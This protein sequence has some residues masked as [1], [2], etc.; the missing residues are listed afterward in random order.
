MAISRK[1]VAGKDSKK[2]KELGSLRRCPTELSPILLVRSLDWMSERIFLPPGS[3]GRCSKSDGSGLR[4]RLGFKN[5]AVFLRSSVGRSVAAHVAWVHHADSDKLAKAL[6]AH[7]EWA[8]AGEAARVE[9][10]VVVLR[11]IVPELRR[12]Y[13]AVADGLSVALTTQDAE[14]TSA[15][16]DRDMQDSLSHP[17]TVSFPSGEL[18][19]EATASV[20][21]P[22]PSPSETESAS[23]CRSF[24]LYSRL[25]RLVHG[26]EADVL[27]LLFDDGLCCDVPL[28]PLPDV[29]LLERLEAFCG[30]TFDPGMSL[31]AAA[32]TALHRDQWPASQ[33]LLLKAGFKFQ[34][35]CSRVGGRQVCCLCVGAEG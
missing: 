1:F 11:G 8:R 21:L 25:S 7:L 10:V 6:S 32:L 35:A 13:A 19:C 26:Q 4:V 3:A 24:H 5:A 20:S 27:P 31:E 14:D 2:S 22:A 23:V 16:D 30:A 29:E 34:Q 9:V 17:I 18:R 12:Q 15:G 33:Q 28:R